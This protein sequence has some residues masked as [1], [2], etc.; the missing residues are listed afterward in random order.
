LNLNQLC[1]LELK[2]LMPV[3]PQTT[4]HRLDSTPTISTFHI[5]IWS[6]MTLNN[7]VITEKYPFRPKRLAV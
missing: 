7:W 6:E 1:E 2:K 3:S 4:I 5:Y